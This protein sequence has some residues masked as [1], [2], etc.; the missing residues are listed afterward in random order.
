MPFG[1]NQI[2]TIAYGDNDIR[3]QEAA[4]KKR[5]TEPLFII[6]KGR[7]QEAYFHHIIYIKLISFIYHW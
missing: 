2:I 1:V 3:T 6:K 5:W 7:K 4:R